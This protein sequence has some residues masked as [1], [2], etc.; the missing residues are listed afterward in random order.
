MTDMA[1]LIKVAAFARLANHA[2][3]KNDFSGHLQTRRRQGRR[4]RA[5]SDGTAPTSRGI[6]SQSHFIMRV[7]RPTIS[8]AMSSP[9]SMRPAR[10]SATLTVAVDGAVRRLVDQPLPV[11]EL[12][13]VSDAVE[14]DRSGRFWAGSKRVQHRD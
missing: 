8:G 1:G 13:D 4:L 2:M 14:N 7:I 9:C 11:R 10:R 12:A 3:P 5:L 6:F